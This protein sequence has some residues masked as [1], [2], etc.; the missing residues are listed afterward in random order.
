M[1]IRLMPATRWGRW[2]AAAVAGFIIFFGLA[3]VAIALG[4]PGGDTFFS[5]PL[6]A[7]PM[8]L[9]GLAGAAA[10]CTGLYGLVRSRERSVLVFITTL[11][12]LFVILFF[13]GELALPL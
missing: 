13:I 1:N 10:F 8:L 12:G 11:A 5:N 6:I 9:A 2:S 4:Q 7:V 3:N